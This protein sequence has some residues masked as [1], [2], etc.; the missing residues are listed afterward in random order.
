MNPAPARKAAF[1]ALLAVD[2]GAWSAEALSAKSIHLDPRDAGLA[3]DI[4]FGVLRRRG[5]LDGVIRQ[6]SKVPLDRLDPEVWIALEMAFYQIRFLD[7]VPSH[8]AVNDA[9]ELARRAGTASA[10]SFVNAVLRQSLR[11]PVEVPETLSTPGWLLDRWSARFGNEI[12]MEIARASL[13]VPE[14]YIRVG[15][16][17]PPAGAEPTDVAGCYRLPDGDPGPFRFQDISAQAVVP[18]LRLETGQTFLDLCASPGNKTAQALETP[19]RAVA[20]DLHLS[21]A[22]MLT[23]LGIPVVVLDA[24][25]PLPFSRKFDRILLDAPCSGTGTLARNPEIKWKLEPEDFAD[26]RQRQI[27]ILRS[28]L[29]Q[30]APG[31][32]LVYATCSLEREENEEVVEAVLSESPAT[33]LE[34]MRRIP[35]RDAGDGFFA[36]VLRP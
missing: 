26:L 5:E 33:V 3:S 13:R 29:A 8:A 25:D 12:A 23:G 36:T 32:L 15:S 31:G 18:L 16:A 9:V 7:R 35:G 11:K 21:R 1:A 27:A 6:Y 28:A 30:L 10:A 2:R 19:L 17:E 24:R 14:R 22:R 20:G 34:T 4:V